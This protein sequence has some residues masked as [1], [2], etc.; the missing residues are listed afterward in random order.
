VAIPN[1]QLYST[2]QSRDQ[3]ALLHQLAAKIIRMSPRLSAEVIVKDGLKQLHCPAKGTTYRALS[4]EA[5]T[6]YGLSPAFVVHDEPGQV[7][8]PRSELFEALET[9][10]SAQ[11][12]PLSV[13]ISTQAPTDN[14]LL[15][16]L[17]DDAIAGHDPHTVCSLYTALVGADPFAVE[18]IRSANPSLGVFQNPEEVLQMAESARRMPAREA[19]FRNLVLNQRIEAS[20]P[21]VMPAQWQACAGAPVDLTGRDVFAGLDL[22]AT[23]D[24]T[25]LVLVGANITD[26]TWHVAPTFWL[27]SEGL[28]D[29]AR[30]DRIPYDV[31]A[32]KG[33]LQTTPGSSVSYE[34]VAKYLRSV[35][36][37][38]RV[39]KLAF[40]R[41][42][43]QHLKPWLLDAGFSEQVIAEKFV[44]FGQGYQSMSPALRDLES[45]ILEK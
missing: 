24:L 11:L 22:S 21:F 37:Q 7:R 18:T 2:A 25:A 27:P 45:I 9:G 30:A 41:W 33:Y 42:N 8:G 36:D 32:S 29:K 34:F 28:H 10:G 3:A 13:V 15:S 23:Q 35:F 4:A 39:G 44:A 5:S 43:M 14:D 38:H 17:I 1:S 20:S 31:W 40:D 12:A 26:G 16:I 19:S 6:A